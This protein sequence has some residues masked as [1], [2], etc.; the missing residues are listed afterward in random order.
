MLDDSPHLAE[1]LQKVTT[2]AQLVLLVPVE[3]SSSSSLSSGAA[4]AAAAEADAAAGGSTGQNHEHLHQ[5]LQPQQTQGLTPP[6]VVINTHLFFHPFAPHIR[7]MHT[8]AMLEEAA[9]AIQQWAAAPE[10]A[11]ALAGAPPPTPLF[12]GDLNSDLNSGVPGV[13]ELLRSGRLGAD[14]WD[15]RDGAAF[16]WVVQQKIVVGMGPWGWALGVGSQALRGVGSVDR[17]PTCTARSSHPTS[18]NCNQHPPKVGQRGRRVRISRRA[19]AA[20]VLSTRSSS[21]CRS[22]SFLP[23]TAQGRPRFRPPNRQPDRPP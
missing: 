15:W 16:R 3:G 4:A 19:A 20:A 14:H 23:A 21:S 11:V 8:A 10:L 6:L 7:S 1:A 22:S 13:V 9:A 12:V 2:I 18:N 17:A 5:Q